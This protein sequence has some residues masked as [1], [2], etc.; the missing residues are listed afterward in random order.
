MSGVLSDFLPSPRATQYFHDPD[1]DLERDLL[2]SPDTGTPVRG[3]SPGM[4]PLSTH[5]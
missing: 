5:Y 3:R 1:L 4:N 2:P